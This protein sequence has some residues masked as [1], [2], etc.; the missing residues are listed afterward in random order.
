MGRGPFLVHPAFYHSTQ[1]PSCRN[2]V[3]LIIS[4]LYRNGICF[5]FAAHRCFRREVVWYGMVWYGMVWYGMVLFFLRQLKILSKFTQIAYVSGPGS[6]S[7][8][9]KL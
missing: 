6:G 1:V 3:A 9:L 5:P 7:L 2:L 8:P 4:F